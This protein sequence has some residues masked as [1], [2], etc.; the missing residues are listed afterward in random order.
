MPSKHAQLIA[1]LSVF[2]VSASLHRFVYANLKRVILRD[3]P[4]LG[5]RLAR[6]AC[7]LFLIMDSP[8]VFLFIRS[9]IH[10]PLAN[11]SKVLLY[12]FS[13]WQAI[14]IMWALVLIPV[15]LWRRSRGLGI[16]WIREQVRRR[17][18]MSEEEPVEA[19]TI[20]PRTA[21]DGFEEQDL[22]IVTE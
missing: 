4:R 3:Y 18:I 20:G 10:E 22:G 21:M 12:P 8:F 1:F 16:F 17:R 11:V 13:V 19:L 14:M 5:K 7:S 6:V 15:A 9:W 2:L